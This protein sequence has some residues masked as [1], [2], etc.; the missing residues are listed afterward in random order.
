MSFLEKLR[1]RQNQNMFIDTIEDLITEQF[2]GK[3]G[4]QWK[5]AYTTFCA[6]HTSAVNLYK[7][8][9]KTDRRFANYVKQCANNPLLK[10]KGIPECILFITTRI[11]K[12][13]LLIDPLI[14]TSS[15][16]PDEERRLM[17]GL[18][19]VKVFSFNNFYFLLCRRSLMS[20]NSKNIIYYNRES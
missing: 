11:T 2:T 12:Y 16:Y 6:Q 13:P 10:K 1:I 8:L 9:E 17:K 18:E 4:E 14:S 3:N 5:L 7:E 15:E 20:L 19:F